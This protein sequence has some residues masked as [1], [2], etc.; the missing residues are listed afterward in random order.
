MRCK[1]AAVPATVTET[2]AHHAI[3]E[4]R[5]GTPETDLEPGDLP[6][7]RIAHSGKEWRLFREEKQGRFPLGKRPFSLHKGVSMKRKKKIAN[8][9]MVVIIVAVAAAGVFFAGRLRGWF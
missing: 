8:I 2:K 4:R 9:V 6:E 7:T 1:T 5:E 3:A